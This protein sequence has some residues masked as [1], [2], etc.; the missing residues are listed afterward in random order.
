MAVGKP[1]PA[2]RVANKLIAPP[3]AARPVID[4]LNVAH[5]WLSGEAFPTVGQGLVSLLDILESSL[6]VSQAYMCWLTVNKHA[7]NA[8]MRLC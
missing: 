4:V 8:R 5:V 1:R 7:N 3:V 2:A 6:T